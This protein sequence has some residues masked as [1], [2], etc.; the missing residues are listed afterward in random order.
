[1]DHWFRKYHLKRSV[2]S[3]G[4]VVFVHELVT[5]SQRRVFDLSGDYIQSWVTAHGV[6]PIVG[7]LIHEGFTRVLGEKLGD[8]IIVYEREFTKLVD[9]GGRVVSVI[10]TPDIVLLKGEVP[11][12]VVDIKFTR[13]PKIP[14]DHHKLQVM[15][16]RW[17]TGAKYSFLLYVCP[18]VGL[19]L[20]EVSEYLTDDDV[21]KLVKETLENLAH[22]RFEWECQYCIYRSICPYVR[23]GS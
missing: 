13:S 12:V 5:C 14:Y 8:Y 4:D 11:E 23:T 10:G 3:S 18:D 1:M 19:K 2:L 7:E 21:A 15:L 16:Y 20:I 9:L 22:P 17:L 6:S